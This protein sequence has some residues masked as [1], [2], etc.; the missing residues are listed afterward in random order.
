MRKILILLILFLASSAF[1][2]VD[3]D[4][5]GPVYS[6]ADGKV[7]TAQNTTDIDLGDSGTV[8]AQLVILA[9]TGTVNVTGTIIATPTGTQ[10]IT[11]TI[12][13]ELVTVSFA[14]EDTTDNVIDT[15]SRLINDTANSL[16]SVGFTTAYKMTIYSVDTT[17][18][19][20]NV[21]AFPTN[22]T[23]RSYSGGSWNTPERYDATVFTNWYIKSPTTG[24]HRYYVVIEGY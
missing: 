8:K 19:Y 11:G 3:T 16:Q 10:T 21:I 23:Y 5:W 9:D 20:T 15:L 6:G 4:K 7:S 17:V 18:I 22:K 24:I 14:F 2:Q 1:A 12:E 13:K